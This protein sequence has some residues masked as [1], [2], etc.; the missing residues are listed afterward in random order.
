MLLP[1]SISFCSV[2]QRMITSLCREARL[3]ASHE[4]A[5]KQATSASDQ[6]QKLME[7]N[8]KLRVS[9]GIQSV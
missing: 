7:E 2:L 8:E 9:L 4:A 6:A 3:E 5:I 1:Y